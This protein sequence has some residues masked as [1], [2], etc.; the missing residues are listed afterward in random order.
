[1]SIIK[2]HKPLS[3]SEIIGRTDKANKECTYV[4]FMAA[5]ENVDESVFDRE[6]LIKS[7]R[8]VA[9]K[10]SHERTD[11]EQVI[12]AIVSNDLELEIIERGKE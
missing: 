4:E 11:F 12:V 1:M 8:R 5:L 7:Y 3:I 10:P 6:A 2:Y 9:A